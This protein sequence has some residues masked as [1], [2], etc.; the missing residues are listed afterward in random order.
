[1]KKQKW[2]I[3]IALVVFVIMML[4]LPYR[5]GGTY[6]HSCNIITGND[7]IGKFQLGMFLARLMLLIGV[8]GGAL[9]F[10]R[11]K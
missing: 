8:T 3:G 7:C 1:M 5:A 4:T 2:I 11:K 6:I 9:Y 10:T